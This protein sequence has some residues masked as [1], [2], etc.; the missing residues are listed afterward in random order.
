[1][2]TTEERSRCAREWRN[3]GKGQ[4]KLTPE[5]AREIKQKL[6]D[7]ST[8]KELAD[9]YKLSISGVSLIKRGLRWK[10]VQIEEVQQ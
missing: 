1:M 10:D 3:K 9:E 7:G 2:Q 6:R 8:G 5:Q 4:T